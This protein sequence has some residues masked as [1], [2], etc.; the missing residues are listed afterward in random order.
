MLLLGVGF[1]G[2]ALCFLAFRDWC[3]SMGFASI[4]GLN[5]SADVGIPGPE[6]IQDWSKT[7]C[8]LCAKPSEILNA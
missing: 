1:P 6:S 5:S 8:T 2:L 4:L 7:W 3:L